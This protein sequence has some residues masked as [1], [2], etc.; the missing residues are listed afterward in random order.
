MYEIDNINFILSSLMENS[1]I[2]YSIIGVIGFIILMCLC[3]YLCKC[4]KEECCNT[5]TVTPED[6]LESAR[7]KKTKSTEYESGNERI[8]RLS[9]M[10]GSK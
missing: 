3:C 5:A 9:E 10:L 4:C 2:I 6:Q 8:F 7:E 1:V